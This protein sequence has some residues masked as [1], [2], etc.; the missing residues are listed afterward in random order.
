MYRWL[1][2]LALIAATAAPSGALADQKSDCLKGVAMIKAQLK[3]KHPQPVLD[4]LRKAL[5]GAETEVAEND[6]PECIDF[7][8]G[9][10]KAMRGK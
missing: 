7:V 4:Q 8:A 3:K 1:P 9:A 2:A 6:W 5:D 10:R